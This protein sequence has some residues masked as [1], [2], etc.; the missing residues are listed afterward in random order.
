MS[1]QPKVSYLGERIRTARKSVGLSQEDLG[2]ILGVSDKTISA[3]EV[4]RAV[5]PL[6]KLLKLA[7]VTRRPVSYFSTETPSVKIEVEERLRLIENL[8]TE[9]KELLEEKTKYVSPRR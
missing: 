9:I 5:P 3:Y 1:N 6:P 7:E 4:G 8:L 2:Q